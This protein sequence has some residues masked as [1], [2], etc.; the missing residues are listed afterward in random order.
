MTEKWIIVPV[1]FLNCFFLETKDTDNTL[2]NSDRK[3]GKTQFSSNHV[4]K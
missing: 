3:K 4:E 2:E 1:S